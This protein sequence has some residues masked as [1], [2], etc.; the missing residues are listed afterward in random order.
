MPIGAVSAL[1][2]PARDQSACPHPE[3]H[4]EGVAHETVFHREPRQKTWTL[5]SFSGFYAHIWIHGLN[6]STNRSAIGFE[7]P[8]AYL[9]ITSI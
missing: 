8:V 5:F 4:V 3:L 7:V 9:P 6:I 1:Q 2:I